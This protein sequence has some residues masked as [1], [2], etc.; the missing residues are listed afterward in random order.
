MF[1]T[2]LDS[3][4]VNITADVGRVQVKRQHPACARA[5]V[6]DRHR[7][8]LARRIGGQQPG[9]PGWIGPAAVVRDPDVRRTGDRGR[10]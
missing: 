5:R 6:I 8:R 10:D 4:T 9:M 7:A 3:N 2:V 1:M